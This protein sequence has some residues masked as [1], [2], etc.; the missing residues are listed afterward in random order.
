VEQRSGPL[1]KL[2]LAPRFVEA[3]ERKFKS[4]P[5]SFA[6]IHVPQGTSDKLMALKQTDFV[7]LVST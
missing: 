7:D 4:K 5:S 3:L 2:P 1:T 6:D